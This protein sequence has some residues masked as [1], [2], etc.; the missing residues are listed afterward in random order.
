MLKVLEKDARVSLLEKSLTFIERFEQNG[1]GERVDKAKKLLKK[2]IPMILS[3][4]SAA[5]SL[6][7]NQRW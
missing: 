3:Q 7:A 6:P 1:D 5:I 2:S 4:L